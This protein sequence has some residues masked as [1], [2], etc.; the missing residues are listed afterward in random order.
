MGMKV[1]FVAILA[2]LA[3]LASH[4]QAN[5]AASAWQDITGGR[6]RFVIADP[7]P[8]DKSLQGML[9]LDLA[10]GWKTY[11]R[12]PGDAGVPLQ[13]DVSKSINASLV[14]VDF[15]APQRFDDGVSVWA[16][17][18]EPVTF[19]LNFERKNATKPLILAG[20]VFLGVC[21]KICVPVQFEFSLDVKDS[22]TPTVHHELVAM[23]LKDMP[24]AATPDFRVETLATDWQTISIEARAPEGSSQAE[25]YLAAPA[26][27]QFT[28]PVLKSQQ[29][30]KLHFEAAFLIV[31]RK[32]VPDPKI[33]AYTLV[34]D[35]GAVS[36]EIALSHR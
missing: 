27:F 19:G 11:W 35:K 21:E 29:G 30:G 31:S 28:A 12:D 20:N 7:V 17:Y 32:L 2:S 3:F 9:Q 18:Q 10:P 6:I 26:G 8:G 15:P 1:F 25:L 33:V 14:S 36:G 22:T 23:A 13:V 5:A 34:T 16:G 4:L 24:P